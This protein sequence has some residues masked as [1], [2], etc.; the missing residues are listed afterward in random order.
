MPSLLDL[1]PELLDEIAELVH[2]T[3]PKQYLGSVH[4]AFL[5]TS[6]RLF[7]RRLI[8]TSFLRL[9]RLCDLLRQ[10]KAVAQSVVHL[11][12]DLAGVD[13]GLPTS[14][15]V[16]ALLESLPSLRSLKVCDNPR[17]LDISANPSPLQ[18]CPL[19]WL[20][21]Q[22]SP[23]PHFGP[24]HPDRF[25]CLLFYKNLSTLT[26][27]SQP[28]ETHP[29]PVQP[30][31]A[32]L[33]INIVDLRLQGR[34]LD[35]PAVPLLLAACPHLLSLTLF[36]DDATQ[37]GMCL[38]FDVLLDAVANPALG[39]LSILDNGDYWHIELGKAIER[40]TELECLALGP[41]CACA[42][43]VPSLQQFPSLDTIIFHPG[44]DITT[45]GILPLLKPS[46]KPPSL[47]V[48]MVRKVEPSWA[49]QHD[50]YDW[51]PSFSKS[52]V[53]ALLTAA[54]EAGV[55]LSGYCV[56]VVKAEQAEQ[57]EALKQAKALKSADGESRKQV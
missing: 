18:Q 43:L 13:P 14:A 35:D 30:S 34:L 7:F 38:P 11:K 29:P 42:E 40:F 41:S 26:I 27:Y 39:K 53:A 55:E 17:I 36:Q 47:R 12:L 28:D 19:E 46:T 51:S 31:P 57:A 20:F 9:D 45:D 48:L 4:R 1:P 24:F 23:A 56:E 8:V 3:L 32:P 5:P 33:R 22:S 15:N 21:L 2:A 6:R 10:G 49:Q 16:A 54:D 50:V 44:A 25:R 37:E 52:G